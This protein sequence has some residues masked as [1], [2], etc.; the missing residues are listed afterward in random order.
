MTVCLDI[1]H[2][3]DRGPDGLG[4]SLGGPATVNVSAYS[5]SL[6]QM[7]FSELLA[8]VQLLERRGRVPDSFVESLR[9]Y[10][11]VASKF[12]F[13]IGGV[14][15]ADSPVHPRGETVWYLFLYHLLASLGVSSALIPA[16]ASTLR[17]LGSEVISGV[18]FGLIAATSA[19]FLSAP[20]FPLSFSSS[21]PTSS[22]VSPGT[23]FPPPSSRYASLASSVPGSVL[24]CPLAPPPSFSVPN[25]SFPC[26]TFLFPF[27]LLSACA[28]WFLL[29]LLLVLKG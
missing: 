29:F 8:T 25:L 17:H 7:S 14:S 21:F 28:L 5:T 11:V 20:P 2:A 6:P 23:S 27:H 16:C 22:F 10:V 18:G 3:R 9:D 15:S 12:D 19:S 1:E 26:L 4:L 13:A 24:L